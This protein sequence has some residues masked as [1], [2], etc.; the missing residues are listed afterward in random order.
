MV[1]EEQRSIFRR[2]AFL[3]GTNWRAL[4]SA[5]N[6]SAKIGRNWQTT[7]KGLQNPSIFLHG[8]GLKDLTQIAIHLSW[9][10]V[11]RSR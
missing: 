3:I 11:I 6:E 9:V 2:R 1:F 8:R 4:G 10:L 7:G 5:E